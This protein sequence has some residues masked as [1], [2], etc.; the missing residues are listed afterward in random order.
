MPLIVPW[1]DIDAAT[2]D[3]L[4]EEFV[5][6]DGTD[7]GEQEIGTGTKVGQVRE[8]LRRGQ[9]SVVFDDATETISI[10]TREQLNELDR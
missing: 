6:R 3:N 4:I 2:L 10:F 5:T 8:Q 7:Y 9:A 1:H